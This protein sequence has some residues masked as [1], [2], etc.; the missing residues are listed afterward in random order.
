MAQ[1]PIAPVH[2]AFT[3]KFGVRLPIVAGGLMWLA[4]AQYVAA[5]AR[6]GILAFITAASFKDLDVLRD[7]IQ[8]CRDLAQGQPF[9][10]NVSMLPQYVT[11]EK[12][13]EVLEL[14]A[15]EGVVY[16]ETSGR[17]PRDY[18]PFI[19]EAGIHLIHKVATVRHAVSA[20][21]L[22]VDAVAIVGAECG[23]HPGIEMVGTMVNTAWAEQQLEIPYLV[24]G[25]VGDGAQI[26]AALAMGAAGVVMGTRF[27]AAD[28]IW[29]HEDYKKRLIAA[30]PTDTALCMH[31]VRNT[32]RALHNETV[33][34]VQEIEQRQENVQIED[35]LPLVRGELARE[36]YRTGDYRRG[37]LSVGQSVAFVAA[38]QSMAQIVQQL[39]EEMHQAFG[40]LDQMRGPTRGDA[41]Q[42]DDKL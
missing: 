2:T 16:V 12:T 41:A 8:K 40:R 21:R 25:G 29:A 5:A 20:Q 14:I 6:S 42:A 31:S 15:D 34:A 35:L 7:E 11:G 32:A 22:G 28:E 3:E 10:V 9:G 37:L 17:S 1:Q 36:A 38:Q 13:Q 30:Q 39:E 4:D 23:G 33:A 27:L 19:K 26:V 24:G 18:M